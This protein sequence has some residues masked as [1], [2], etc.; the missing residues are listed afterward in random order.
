M[1]RCVTSEL[2]NMRR[3]LQDIEADLNKLFS[4]EYTKEKPRSNSPLKGLGHAD[5][6]DSSLAKLFDKVD[7]GFRKRNEKHILEVFQRYW[8]EEIPGI[9]RRKLS[10]ALEELGIFLVKEELN[11]FF[12]MMDTTGDGVLDFEEFKRAVHYPGPIEQ[13]AKTMNLAQLLSDSV[14]VPEGVDALRALSQISSA[15]IDRTC[16]AFSYGL[17]R[18][19]TEHIQVL[20][21][22][23]ETRDLRDAEADMKAS[24]FEV[25][26]LSCGKIQ[27]FHKGISGRIGN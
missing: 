1:R 23:F 27:D 7:T 4:S 25:F 19:I 21:T 14:P 18:M 26:S 12:E 13:W 5:R 8:E 15:D 2:E 20:Q 22:S 16:A 3:S 11:E 10:D 6:A 9:S 17:R 24:K